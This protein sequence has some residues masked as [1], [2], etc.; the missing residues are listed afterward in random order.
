M[1]F[2]LWN[3]INNN[4]YYK[5]YLRDHSYWYKPLNR[6]PRVFTQFENEVKCVYHLRKSDQILGLIDKIEMGSMIVKMLKG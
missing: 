5:Q 6:D 3:K 4:P 2:D 1:R